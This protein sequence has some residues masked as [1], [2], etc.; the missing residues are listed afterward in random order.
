MESDE[1]SKSTK[2]KVKVNPDKVKVKDG[3]E[4][5]EI[6]N[7]PTLTHLMVGFR[8]P[9]IILFHSS[10]DSQ[11]DSR[12]SIAILVGDNDSGIQLPG[13]EGGEVKGVGVA[14]RVAR[15]SLREKPDGAMEVIGG[16]S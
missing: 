8:N 7:G 15:S 16:V 11:N 13:D 14:F 4:T 12:L 3:A 1:K 9:I 2:D 5:E 10:I 6:L